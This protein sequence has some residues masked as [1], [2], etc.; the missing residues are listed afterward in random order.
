VCRL[1]APAILVAALAP[2]LLTTVCP[3]EQ[4]TRFPAVS[5]DSYFVILLVATLC[6]V[7]AVWLRSVRIP[8]WRGIDSRRT[9]CLAWASALAN[10]EVR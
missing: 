9:H 3:G 5:A 7:V 4:H 8:G 1:P 2:L 6:S 10:H